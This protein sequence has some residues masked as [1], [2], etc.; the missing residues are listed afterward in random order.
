[1]TLLWSKHVGAA[2]KEDLIFTFT[3]TRADVYI[4]TLI[5]KVHG[6]ESHSRKS[7]SAHK[8]KACEGVK[9]GVHAFL[10]SAVSFTPRL[11]HCGDRSSVRM[12]RGLGE[13]AQ[14]VD[15]MDTIPFPHRESN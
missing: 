12:S 15:I 4:S 1:M 2:I 11:L 8:K 13:E 9:V 7:F 14:P 3:S 10:I 5:T 6:Y